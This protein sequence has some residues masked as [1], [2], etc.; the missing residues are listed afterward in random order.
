MFQEPWNSG[1]GLYK[2]LF[3]GSQ[4]VLTGHDGILLEICKQEMDMQ[5]SRH[6]TV[7]QVE[8]VQDWANS[9]EVGN[10]EWKANIVELR[11]KPI[12][13]T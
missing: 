3:S 1:R 4:E 11:P 7:L 6:Q 2:I 12:I 8:A 13:R 9:V 10:M 5:P